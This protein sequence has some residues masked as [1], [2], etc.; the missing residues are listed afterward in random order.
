MHGY[1]KTGL[2]MSLTVFLLGF[3]HPVHAQSS[4]EK[5]ELIQK[6]VDLM[7]FEAVVVQATDAMSQQVVATVTANKPDIPQEALDIIVAVVREEGKILL[8]GTMQEVGP[9]LGKYYTVDEIRGLV[10]FY[11]T[12][13][14]QKAIRI[15]PQVMNDIP[16]VMLPHMQAFQN[17]FPVKL[18]ARLAEAGYE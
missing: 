2:A 8:E 15:M 14:G 4:A 18:K 7:E 12:P 13:L 9:L 17:S 1:M 11:E 16:A 5:D 6:L 10:E 3:G